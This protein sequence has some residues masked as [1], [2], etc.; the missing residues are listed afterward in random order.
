M[1]GLLAFPRQRL[2]DAPILLGFM[3]CL[4]HDFPILSIPAQYL[5]I[6]NDHEFST[7]ILVDGFNHLEKSWKI[8]VRQWDWW[9]PFFIKWKIKNAWNHQPVSTC[10][11]D[12]TNTWP[13]RSIFQRPAMTSIAC[14]TSVNIGPL[15][16]I[17]I[18]P[19]HLWPSSR[20][21]PFFRRSSVNFLVFYP[22]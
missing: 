22:C 12:L 3:G 4:G 6:Q 19:E 21:H 1:V 8:W 18:G 17:Q 15:P 5:Y 11:T 2:H 9:H 7:Y 14:E 10:Q 20:N 13:M 16:A